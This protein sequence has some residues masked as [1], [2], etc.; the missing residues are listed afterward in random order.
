MKKTILTLLWMAIALFL[1][2]RAFTPDKL[3]ATRAA[4]MKGDALAQYY[5]GTNYYDGD[6]VAQDKA[7]AAVVSHDR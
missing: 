4:A 7:E 6:G 5:L 2:T 1:A 3:E